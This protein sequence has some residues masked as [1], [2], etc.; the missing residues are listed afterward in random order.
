[1]SMDAYR[2]VITGHDGQGR[3]I[4][5]FDGPTVDLGTLREIWSTTGSPAA[6]GA[7]EHPTTQTIRIAPPELGSIFRLVTIEP[8]SRFAKLS[9]EE[10]RQRTR[11]AFAA[12][13]SGDA[14]V[15]TRLHPAMHR[16]DTVDYIVVLSGT[17]IMKLEIGE[18][19]LNPFDV[20]VQ[21]GTNHAWI[22]PGDQPAL[23][24]AVLVDARRE[25]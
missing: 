9:A 16:T 4:V 23:L 2:R 24:A 25:A 12:I 7:V 22:N 19:H 5:E 8:E 17:L 13:D 1:M 11:S 21:R 6:I 15:D 18:V 3:S 14:L 10:W 20:V